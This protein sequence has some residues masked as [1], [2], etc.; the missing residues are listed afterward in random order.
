[1]NRLLLAVVA[2][3]VIAL[4]GFAIFVIASGGSGPPSLVATST[5][6]AGSPPAA[7][8]SGTAAP[9]PRAAGS[10]P[11]AGSDPEANQ[12]FAAWQ[13]SMT[14]VGFTV[15]AGRVA[16]LDNALAVTR[17]NVTGSGWN[18]T[19][20]S[21]RVTVA[22]KDNFDITAS[23]KQT[24]S[25]TFNG[26]AAEYG[27]NVNQL[28]VGYH[29]GNGRILSF[30]FLNLTVESD[31]DAAPITLESGGLRFVAGPGDEFVPDATEGE[32]RVNKLVLPALAGYPLGTK[33]DTLSAT[34]FF[35]KALPSGDPS[36]A[37]QP[38]L[39]ESDALGLPV[40]SLTWGTLKFAG[41]GVVGLDD[42]GNPTGRFEVRIADVLAMLDSFHTLGRFDRDELAKLYAKLLLEDSR[43]GN[44]LGLQFPITVANGVVTLV[45]Q[46]HGI[47]DIPLGTVG[48]LYAPSGSNR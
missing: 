7:S 34:L 43:V 9:A 17:L 10:A 18:W 37:L 6:Q 14:A 8:A 30:E 38:W 36:N 11:Q 45:G 22:N 21:A 40:L 13:Q 19:A 20:A 12:R 15:E 41:V 35:Q 42:A 2:L 16:I 48:R 32:L 29:K 1:V 24:V 46:S 26:K 31:Q 44:S 5:P 47:D 28:R 27:A 39:G 3:A 25:F 33:I 4:T 23:G